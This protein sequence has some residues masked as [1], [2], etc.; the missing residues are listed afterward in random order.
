[1]MKLFIGAEGT[2]GVIIRITLRLLP[3]PTE[4]RTVAAFVTTREAAFDAGADI[5]KAMRPS[6]I[7]VMDRPALAVAEQHLRMGLDD[8]TAA[9]LFGYSA[10]GNVHLGPERRAGCCF[11]VGG[12]ADSRCVREGG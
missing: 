1:M 2:L 8:D 10:H 7:A 4:H 12:L 11:R 6:E 3:K 5:A 9:V